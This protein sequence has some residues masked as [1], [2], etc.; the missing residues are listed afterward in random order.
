MGRPDPDLAWMV[1]WGS[2]ETIFLVTYLHCHWRK[3]TRNRPK[4]FLEFGHVLSFLSIASTLKHGNCESFG[5]LH[6]SALLHGCKETALEL[7]ALAIRKPASHVLINQVAFDSLY[8]LHE[9]LISEG[10]LLYLNLLLFRQIAKQVSNK[11]RFGRR[12]V[13]H[14]GLSLY[15]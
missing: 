10:E 7:S 8:G 12:F 2:D 5:E 1:L 11:Q 4:R 3:G 14:S 13:S 6:F 9:L 15:T